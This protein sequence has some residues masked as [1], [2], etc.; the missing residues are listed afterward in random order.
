MRRSREDFGGSHPAATKPA[1]R[2]SYGVACAFLLAAGIAALLPAAPTF[3][4][5]PGKDV[6]Q[7]RHI[8]RS[9]ILR[10][11]TTRLSLLR[12]RHAPG[13]VWR[14]VWNRVTPPD[15]WQDLTGVT[16]TK[17]GETST[18]LPNTWMIPTTEGDLF[19]V[20]KSQGQWRIIGRG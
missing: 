15:R 9:E 13:Q 20:D 1:R 14:S 8:V 11:A 10:S 19:F 16:Q 2:V 4:G 18:F 3:N 5:L 7:I 12:I 17:S 6:A